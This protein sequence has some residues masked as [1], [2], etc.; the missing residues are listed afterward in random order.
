MTAT[1]L[2]EQIFSDALARPAGPQRARYL[3][4]VCGA[5]AQVR[6]RVERLLRASG[7]AESFLESPAADPAPTIEQPPSER[8]GTQI[9]PYKLLQQI[10]EGGFGVVYMAE[11]LEPVRRKVALKV[12]KP[13]MD[14]RQVIARFEAERQ[15]LAVM[16]HPNIAK[17]LDAGTVGEKPEVRGQKSEVGG[18]GL[19]ISD[20]RPLTSRPYFVMELVRGIPI[21]QYCDENQVPIRER[22]ELF[23]TV[24]QAIQHAHTKGIIHRDIKPT[25]VLVTQQDGQPIVKVI[26]F[27]IAKAMGQQLTDKTLFTEFAQ[28]IGTPQYMSPEQA[29]MSSVDIDT[30]SDIY[31]LG[32]LLYELLTGSTPVSKEQLKQATFDEIRRI[33]REDEA[34]KPSL[35][36]G[37]SDT[38][39]A[40]AAHRHVETGRLKLLVRGEL[41]WI[42]MKCLEKDR[43]RRY[44]TAGS[45]GR[46]VQR[47]L[48]DEQVQACPPSAWYRLRKLARRHKGALVS[49]SAVALA[50]LLAVTALAVS[51][52][53]V[54]RAYQELRSEMYFQR[55]TVAQRELSM[56][57]LAA[58]L[59]ALQECPEDLRGWEWHYLM[60]LLKVEPLVIRDRA[61]I[62]GVAFSPDGERIVSA[63]GDGAIRI[64]N[65][66]TGKFIREISGA[67][68][69]AVCCVVF[70]PKGEHLASAGADGWVKI[71]DL[72]S[73]PEREV[74][75][76]KCDALRKFAAAYT[77]AF[78]PLDGRHLAA[79]SNGT[80]TLWDWT[81]QKPLHPF[82]GHEH[83]SIPVAFSQDGR[84]LATGGG[85]RGQCI[86]D[87]E[88]RRLVRT[89][90]A[91]QL[92]VSALA[93]SPDGGW[94]ATSSVDRSLKLWNTKTGEPIREFL[95]TGNV[96]GV[97]FSPDGKRL[98]STGEDKTVHV[99]DATNFREV[100]SLRGHADSCPCVVFSP[101]GHR[102][103][104]GSLDGTIRVWDATPL[105]ED[106]GEKTTFAH[107]ET[108]L[109]CV[110][111]S[112]DGEKLVSAGHGG[113]LK[114]WDA[115][116]GQRIVEIPG[117]QVLVFAVAW[118]P[119]SQRIASAGS[120]GSQRAVR[121]WDVRNGR[122]LFEIAAGGENF[123]VPFQAVAF[124]PGPEGRHLVTGN[125]DGVV[126]VWDAQT[127]QRV[128][129]LGTHD[130]E[131]RGLVFSP[132]GKH[133]ASA[134]G[135]GEVKL[136]DATRLD[137]EQAPSLPSFRARVPVPCLNVAFSPDSQRLA[138]GGKGNTVK[139]WDVQTSKEHT[140]QGHS[141]D[142]YSVAFSPNDNG[143]WLASGGEDST[144]K[145]WDSR[146]GELV[147]TFRGHT[148]LVSSLAFS[149]DGRRLY[150]GSRDATVKVWDVAQIEI[151][152]DR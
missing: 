111:M 1:P 54:W 119:D 29:A 137:Q 41:D 138:A 117:H 82:A 96:L 129:R 11:Q 66:R 46:D 128:R 37:S 13:G 4:E 5:D 106:E 43:N 124:S 67:H 27:G 23:A 16:D 109:R 112:P 86:F 69:K 116:T 92:P 59:A 12:I 32:V 74:F 136:W 9:G 87:L 33:I 152:P 47:Y 53:L 108:E 145:I 141:G 44:E 85:Q 71:W 142:V 40:I 104:S 114:I 56:D 73:D 88:T 135:D 120:D 146:S 127:G 132:S 105:G 123:A 2:I 19:L 122:K 144:V 58:A 150:S 22:L 89:L 83:N 14:T 60:R 99:W 38:L 102:L 79:G 80:V 55:I 113:L 70:H 25:N 10:G 8:P 91:H 133:L 35:R 34:Q 110:A 118:H 131:I 24:C 61:E 93:F 30:R 94:L 31:S 76:E 148:G 126:E 64:W 100:L 151:V 17:V 63:G 50:A 101:D 77:V 98:V 21:T 75:R 130:R 95:H 49:V 6:E 134:S 7:D 57:N 26:D 90:P 139:V 20:L 97:A 51:A 121:V 65:S 18:G 36:I 42:V 147:R 84:Q 15:A 28:M 143:R 149:P 81:N 39:P 72:S 140:F 103:A 3:D 107:H 48:A 68:D 52:G 78:R 115:A 62:L 45:L 125:Q